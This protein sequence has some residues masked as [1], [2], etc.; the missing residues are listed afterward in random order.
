MRNARAYDQCHRRKGVHR[1]LQIT[2]I[3]LWTRMK[4][5]DGVVDISHDA[6]NLRRLVI[7]I[8]YLNLSALSVSLGEEA[9][10]EFLID[11]GH[12]GIVG[13]IVGRKPPSSQNRN[14]HRVKIFR[15]DN[16]ELR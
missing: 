7:A 15:P 14:F 9:P 5:S 10:C 13:V 2:L 16:K 1:N 6:D 11:E 8:L 3:N 12:D 4:L